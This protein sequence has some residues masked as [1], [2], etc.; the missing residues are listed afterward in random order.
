MKYSLEQKKK[1]GSVCSDI[2]N[3]NWTDATNKCVDEGWDTYTL[4]SMKEAFE[5]TGD[6]E[7]MLSLRDLAIL[8]MYIER[9][10]YERKEYE[11][12]STQK[13]MEIS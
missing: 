2:Y 13:D 11:N 9:L 1:L 3:G 5:F 6:S 10:R 4:L 7:W 12:N 8:G